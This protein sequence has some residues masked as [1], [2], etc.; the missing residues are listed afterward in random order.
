[1]VD[2]RELVGRPTGVGRYLAGI[3]GAWAA[4]GAFPH[5]VTLFLPSALPAS[6]AA[7]LGAF[8]SRVD[9][10]ARAGT[11]WEQMRLPRAAAAAGVDVFFAAGYTSPFLLTCPSVVAIYDVSFF[12]HPE[13]FS[14]REGLRRRMLTRS[15]ARRARGVIT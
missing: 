10:A 2:A 11:W 6:L 12:A 8:D 13:W 15:A 5:R 4:D 9:S 7:P 3:L 14:W 1:G